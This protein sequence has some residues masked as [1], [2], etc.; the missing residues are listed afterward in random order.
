MWHWGAHNARLVGFIGGME[1]ESG[2]AIVGR[3]ECPSSYV[4]TGWEVGF[5][6]RLLAEWG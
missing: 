4:V 5:W 2:L 1:W 6:E 3:L